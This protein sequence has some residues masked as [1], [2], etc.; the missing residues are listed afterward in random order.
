VSPRAQLVMTK[1]LRLSTNHDV[2]RV[3]AF[4]AL[5]HN[6]VGVQQDGRVRR[7]TVR[8]GL[9]DTGKNDVVN[10]ALVAAVGGSVRVSGE[11]RQHAAM[12]VQSPQNLVVIPH[13]T[14]GRAA[15][16]TY[17]DVTWQTKQ[18]RLE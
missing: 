11:V 12:V 14:L 18:P 1:L 4:G 6:T 3:T 7:G 10:S 15:V 8:R 9:N 17:R 16:H 13:Q 5:N 2:G